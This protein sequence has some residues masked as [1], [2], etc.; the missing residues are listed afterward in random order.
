MRRKQV[1]NMRRKE[2]IN[3]MRLIM[4]GTKLHTDVNWLC[5]PV[6]FCMSLK[7]SEVK[8]F[9][10][11]VSRHLFHIIGK[12]D[13]SISLNFRLYFQCK[14]S[15]LRH[16]NAQYSIDLYWIY[17]VWGK[18]QM[19]QNLTFLKGEVWTQIRK[20]IFLVALKLVCH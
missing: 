18:K 3:T 13:L 19:M 7:S 20:D 8:N 14:L 5:Y 16:E 12:I 2:G 1:N 15:V 11:S 9:Y 4:T 6:N 10:K 17:S